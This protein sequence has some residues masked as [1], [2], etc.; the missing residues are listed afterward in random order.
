M[1][2]RS[3]LHT[4][5]EVHRS[6]QSP[7]HSPNESSL[8]TCGE[9]VCCD[10]AALRFWLTGHTTHGIS[11]SPH[12][13]LTLT[14]M[15]AQLW[16]TRSHRASAQFFPLAESSL[17]GGT[18]CKETYASTARGKFWTF[19]GLQLGVPLKWE[20]HEGLLNSSQESYQRTKFDPNGTLY[21]SSG[22]V[23]FG[24]VRVRREGVRGLFREQRERLWDIQG[25]PPRG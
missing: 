22:E 19:R 5:T 21:S 1:R 8:R 15:L 12:H 10:S 2:T 24:C 13:T 18:H 17:A 23:N 9:A 3:H 4:D 25:S 14:Q 7:T 20:T 16:A 6:T 11:L